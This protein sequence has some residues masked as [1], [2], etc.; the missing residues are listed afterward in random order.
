MPA[1]TG[2]QG[3]RDTPPL[4]SRFRGSDDVVALHPH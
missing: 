1:Q 3:N 4:D 2:I